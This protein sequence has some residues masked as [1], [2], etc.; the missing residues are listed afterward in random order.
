MINLGVSKPIFVFPHG[1]EKGKFPFKQRKKDGVFKF[2]YVGE[3]SE[4]KG[5]FHLVKAFI[6]LFENNTL[7]ELHLRSNNVMVFYGGEELQKLIE[8]HNNIFWDHTN[9]THEELIKLYEECHPYVYP[10]SRY[11]WNDSS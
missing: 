8:P 2:L 1:I 4:R 6:D 11:F 5:T 3:C 9:T 10:S 7:V